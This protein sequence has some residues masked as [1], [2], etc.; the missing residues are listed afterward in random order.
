MSTVAEVAA[1]LEV[2]APA[3]LAAEWD[4]VGLL[5]GDHALDV[6][7]VMTCLT[8]TPDSAEEAVE[9]GAQLIVTHHPLPFRGVRRLTA[10]SHDGR[11]L[12]MLIRA[13][14]SVY[15]PHTAFDSAVDG[16]NQQLAT[17]L[18]L[19]YIEALIP[20]DESVQTRT[21]SPGTGRF[22]ALPQ[23]V[24]LKTLIESIKKSLHLNALQYVGRPSQQVSRVGIGCG[25]AG[26]FLSTA[27]EKGC[28]AFL[29]GE[30]RFHDCL[31]AEAEGTAVILLGHYASERF[32][33][34]QLATV[35]ARQ[36]SDCQVWPSQ[37]EADPIRFA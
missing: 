20:A 21:Q 8:I 14:V 18:G 1:F 17:H 19:N 9:Q 24:E 6:N 13:G 5:V 27:S 28:D 23:P 10:D 7:K 26:E 2:F 30:M 37:R 35:L 33:V 29:T 11:L 25:S 34:E 36:F 22:G 3:S 15:S 4:N 31:H 12:W 16:I 32:A